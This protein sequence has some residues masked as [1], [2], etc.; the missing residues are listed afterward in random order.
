LL[1]VDQIILVV[2]IELDYY[3]GYFCFR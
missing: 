2:W 3:D 1:E